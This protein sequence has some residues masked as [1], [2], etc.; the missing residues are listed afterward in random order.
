MQTATG[1]FRVEV[2]RTVEEIE[3]LKLVWD[4]VAW[5]R[6]DAE[7]HEFLARVRL[8]DNVV[9]PFAILVF[10]GA[11]P[12][13]AVAARIELRPLQTNVGY[14]VVYAPKVT[15]LQVVP[16]G[17]VSSDA[18]ALALLV[19]AL[20]A[21]LADGEADVVALPPL[22]V[23]S[24]LYAVVRSLGGPLERQRFV[25]AWTRRQLALP[26]AFAEFLASRSRTTRRGV[27][28]AANRLEAEFGETLRV[29]TVREPGHLDRLVRD[30]DTVAGATYQRT[31][32]AGFADTPE[33][34]ELL[35]VG[36]E[37]GRVLAYLLYIGDQ[38]I[39]Y[40]LCSVH[41]GTMYLTT[42]G[43]DHAYA[44]QRVGVY[45]LMRVLEDA[46]ADPLVRTFDFGPGDTDYKRWFSDEGVRER[47]L[48]VFAPTF[49][50]RRINAVR[51]AILGV[52]L[53]A[54]KLADA[55]RLTARLRGRWKRRLR[56]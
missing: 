6:D 30:L 3:R 11:R 5:E 10:L 38:P 15:V 19:D 44:S 20:A 26:A 7:F 46:C 55:T 51:T 50:A 45:L 41:R 31:L 29:E 36:L 56:P 18:G 2:V 53:I 22:P 39:A 9:S 28:N 1:Q 52:A 48:F 37:Q 12:V 32:G 27:R 21:A 14:R 4:A 8:R 35:R 17:I 13:A 43:F 33:Q 49:R 54:R 47:N 40:W 16:G 24:D 34:R 25:A 42:G 23:D